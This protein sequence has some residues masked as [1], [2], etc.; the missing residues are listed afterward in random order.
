MCNRTNQSS[1]IIPNADLCIPN[2]EGSGD[3]YF[4]GPCNTTECLSMEKKCRYAGG[5][6][7]Y[8]EVNDAHF[9]GL[10]DSGTYKNYYQVECG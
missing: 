6:N 7:E 10:R 9:C 3:S 8:C 4:F 5:R 2:Y 1:Y